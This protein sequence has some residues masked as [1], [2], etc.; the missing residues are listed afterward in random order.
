MK[1]LLPVTVTVAGALLVAGCGSDSKPLPLT[2]TLSV[3]EHSAAD[4][5]KGGPGYYAP[6][7]FTAG[8]P[9]QPCHGNASYA[10]LIST[11]RVTVVDK[12]G[13]QVGAAPLGDATI[14][15]ELE[16]RW[17]LAFT[18][19]GGK[20]PYTIDVAGKAKINV[21]EAEVKKGSMDLAIGT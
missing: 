4:M 7:Q 2:A 10:F 21:T 20:G 15:P 5:V 1:L 14:D 3:P 8:Q 19:P 9:G 12:S 16:C 18:V 17:K 11:A 13:K 6:K